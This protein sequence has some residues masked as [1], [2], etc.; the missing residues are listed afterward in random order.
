MMGSPVAGSIFGGGTS[1]WQ[2]KCSPERTIAQLNNL[3][4]ERETET[5]RELSCR[6]CRRFRAGSKK[7]TLLTASP[8]NPVSNGNQNDD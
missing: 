1:Q 5:H 4:N 2:R 8:R 6:V 3:T 7:T